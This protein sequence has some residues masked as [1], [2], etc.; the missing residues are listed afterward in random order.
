[1]PGRTEHPAERWLPSQDGLE[2]R[3]YS[4]KTPAAE[5][6]PRSDPLDSEGIRNPQVFLNP[7]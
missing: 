4:Y 2:S 1:M 3:P 7:D 6:L 5:S